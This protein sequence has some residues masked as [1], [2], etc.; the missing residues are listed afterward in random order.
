MGK[1]AQVA[2]EYMILTGF[3][4]VIVTIT[5]GASYVSFDL[6]TKI[7]QTN[8]FV[9]SLVNS[10]DGIYVLGPGN[11]ALV[12]TTIP[13]GTESISAEY[14]CTDSISQ[15]IA[16]CGGPS[17]VNFTEIS[18]DISLVTGTTSIKSV[19]RAPMEFLDDAEGKSFPCTTNSEFCSGVYNLFICWEPAEAGVQACTG[20]TDGVICVKKV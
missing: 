16:G 5:F 11:I 2:V 3:I 1:K 19:A 10:I 18:L 17:D 9:D 7:A 20:C 8:K 12:N 14:V 4:L 13:M 15:T 6:N